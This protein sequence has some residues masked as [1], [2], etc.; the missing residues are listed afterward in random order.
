MKE[1]TGIP[2]GSLIIEDVGSTNALV[3]LSVFPQN[4]I[5]QKRSPLLVGYG[6]VLCSSVTPG[7]IN[8]MTEAERYSAL[9]NDN[10]SET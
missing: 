8:L 9:L 7:E 5:T 1:F 4:F 3:I 2:W 6:H 10:V